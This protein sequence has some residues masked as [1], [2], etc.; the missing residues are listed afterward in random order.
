ME[1]QDIKDL[2]ARITQLC[3][4]FIV[5]VKGTVIHSYDIILLNHLIAHSIDEILL[6]KKPD[7]GK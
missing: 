5:E 1:D 6:K 3:Q 4:H 2:K 7:D